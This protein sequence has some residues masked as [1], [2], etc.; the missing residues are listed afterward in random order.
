MKTFWEESAIALKLPLP[1]RHYV[2]PMTR[3]LDTCQIAFTDLTLSDGSSV[4]AFNPIIKEMVRERLGVHTCDRRHPRSWISETHPKFTIEE[5]F[6]EE[7]K[8]WKPNERETLAQH[9]V[10]IRAFLNELF[11]TDNEP[12]ISVTCHSGSI[13]AFHKV[14]GHPSV[15]VAP[16]AIV[17]LLIK[18]KAI[19]DN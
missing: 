10:R 1:K 17:P 15:Y 3:C 19:P 14:I 8:L 11:A 6:S 7:D 9:A 4:P 18:A 12:I 13:R 16:G 5:E 2:S